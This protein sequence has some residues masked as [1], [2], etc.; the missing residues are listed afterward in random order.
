MDTNGGTRRV[1]GYGLTLITAYLL[2]SVQWKTAFS[3]SVKWS[4]GVRREQAERQSAAL[5]SSLR[6]MKSSTIGAER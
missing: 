5:L 3:A 2:Y 6:L 4:G 1:H